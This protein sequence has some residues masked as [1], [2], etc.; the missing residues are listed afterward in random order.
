VRPEQLAT[1]HRF[2]P[3]KE[4]TVRILSS[5]IG[6]LVVC[7]LA[8]IDPQ[9]AQAQNTP[10]AHAPQV[11][12]V[13]SST[14]D[15]TSDLKVITELAGPQGVKG[16]KAFKDLLDLTFEG[17]DPKRPLVLDVLVNPTGSEMRAYF[18]VVGQPG[19][20]LG[21][22]FLGNLAGIGIKQKKLVQNFYQLGGGAAPMQGSAFDGYLRLLP[23]PTNCAVIAK[24][25]EV[26]P[27]NL[28]DPTKDKVVAAL[29]AKAFDVG[30][31]VKNDKLDAAS[32]QA[33]RADFQK[34]KSELLAGLKQKPETTAEEFAVDQAVFRHLLE[35]VE[36][37]VAESS[38]LT[39]G[40][41]TDAPKKEARLDFEL[42]TAPGS[43][44]EESAKQL[45]QTPSLFANVARSEN[46]ILSGRLNFPLDTLRKTNALAGIPLLRARANARIA[47][48]TS[49]TDDQKTAFKAAA[50][51]WYDMLEA[52][53]NAG[54]LDG[55]I[56][57]SQAKEEKAN[58][59]CGIKV[60][61]GQPLVPI[62]ELIPA[63]STGLKVQLNVEK[64]GD[65]SLHKLQIPEDI[66]EFNLLFGKGA[67]IHLA[68]GPKAVWLAI[69]A[70]SLEQLKPAIEAT[71]QEH[72]APA[73]QFLALFLRVSPWVEWLH[74]VRSEQD[75]KPSEKKLTEEE[76][77]VKSERDALRKRA[78]ESLKL[79]QDTIET[80]MSA[81]GGQVSGSTR[82][83]EG[84][85]RFIGNEI[86]NFSNTTLK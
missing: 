78:L 59:L 46:A 71:H 77:R 86:A 66:T 16:W 63:I 42:A 72:N 40:W 54:V 26:L 76:A 82:Y 10:A 58:L 23:A 15:L 62:L 75:A 44:L 51:L 85:L 9:R 68:T 18:P 49:R 48:S 65:Y 30:L 50:N 34:A 11:H 60:L 69:G 74:G 45:G 3:L 73:D 20:Q 84:I 79:G 38:E 13:L 28:G 43:S 41:I 36:R 12:A 22:Q 1:D 27:P 33:R 14:D 37:F 29:L 4:T 80:K 64:V 67:P 7:G 61:D 81:K 56:E 6:S 47:A 25:R 24:K 31:I 70:K 55:M 2:L 39:L 35:E 32:I 21:Q 52:N 17:V 8:A 53:V 57:I 5:L 83:G 19:P